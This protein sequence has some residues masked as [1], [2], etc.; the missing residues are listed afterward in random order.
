[1]KVIEERYLKKE[2]KKLNRYSVEHRNFLDFFNNVD[3]VMDT[4]LQ[5]LS[6]KS[7]LNFFKEIEFIL[8]VITSIVSHPHLVNKGEEIIV[9]A[10]QANHVSTE[11]FNKTMRDA[12]L[13]KENDQTDMVPEYVYYYQQIDELRIYENIFICMLVKMIEQ[14]INKYS[15]FYVSTILTFNNQDTLSVNKDNSDI[16][17]DKMNSI[18]RRIK[19]IKNSYFFKTIN[20]GGTKLGHI[21][22]TNILTKDRL[23]NFCYKFYRKM[24]TYTDNYSRLQDIRA[25][26]YI[27]FIKVIKEFGFKP[28]G[29][30]SLQMKGVR[31]F[32][33]PKAKFANE[34]Y[35]LSLCQVEKY[36][37]LILEIE[38]RNVKVKKSNKSKHLLLFD[39][40][41]GFS[42]E[43]Y[44]IE[45]DKFDTVEILSL[46]NMGYVEGN[47][48]PLYPNP[49]S[50]NL[51]MKEWITSKIR[52]VIGSKKIYSIYCPSCKSQMLQ[53]AN[54]GHIRCEICSS[55]YTF[56]KNELGENIW[57]SRLRRG[58]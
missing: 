43:T 20:K 3:P 30:D 6:F 45:Y 47:V 55:K 7:D 52:N 2:I 18:M 1:M 8:S 24:I 44:E 41:P 16:A 10:D 40:K 34:N 35:V 46:W 58:V 38:N 32:N 36:T 23:Y 17:L 28:Y 12:L 21:H 39:S 54:N 26:Y 19:H 25:F 42:D 11:M 14:E 4:T 50:E 56:Y 53:V 57:F 9:R 31:K 48:H 37:G 51:M 29:C 15:E 49:I 22:P 33:V 27:Q 5:D 13:W